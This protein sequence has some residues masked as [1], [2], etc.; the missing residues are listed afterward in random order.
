MTKITWT[1]FGKICFKYS[2]LTF[3]CLVHVPFIYM[4]EAGFM[5]YTAASHQGVHITSS[6]FIYILCYWV[7]RYLERTIMPDETHTDKH[8]SMSLPSMAQ[9]GWALLFLLGSWRSVEEGL[10]RPRTGSLPWA[11]PLP[12]AE[13]AE[14]LQ[15]SPP[16]ARDA[17]RSGPPTNSHQGSSGCTK[18][19]GRSRLQMVLRSKG[20]RSRNRKR[21]H[22]HHSANGQK[23]HSGCFPGKAEEKAQEE[24]RSKVSTDAWRVVRWAKCAKRRGE[25]ESLCG[26]SLRE[27]SSYLQQTLSV[28]ARCSFSVNVNQDKPTGPNHALNQL[29]GF[30]QAP[31]L[32]HCSYKL[33][34]NTWAGAASALS[35]NKN[36]CCNKRT[37]C[38][39]FS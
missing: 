26:T 33:L 29:T 10:P 2:L 18:V 34:Y 3:F 17:L 30:A 31:Q 22:S 11:P 21:Q 25:E 16:S 20:E 23:S 32:S 36:Q 19:T 13:V 15:G 28:K 37:I 27:Y 12:G 6:V 1:I 5:T 39:A 9:L 38:A 7:E 14:P 35:G 8:S 4:E 24:H